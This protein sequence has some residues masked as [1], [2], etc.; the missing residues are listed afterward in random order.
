M[1]TGSRR[2][3]VMKAKSLPV[4]IWDTLLEAHR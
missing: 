1:T 4:M 2:F 3:G